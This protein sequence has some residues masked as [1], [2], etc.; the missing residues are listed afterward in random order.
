[1]SS[2]AA[3]EG[4]PAATPLARPTGSRANGWW[5]M[6]LLIATE[7]TLFAVLIASYFY[8]RFKSPVWPPDGINEPTLGRPLLNNGILLA[9]IAPIYFAEYAAVRGRQ[10]LLRLGLLGS[11]LLMLAYF[12][13]QLDSF[14]TSWHAFK[15]SQDTYASLVYAIVGAH[16]LHVGAGILLVAFVFVRALLGHFGAERN[17]PVQ[18]TA[19]YV[20]FVGLLAIP[21]F[22]TS[23]SPAL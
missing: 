9:S 20:H 17:V 14:W 16:W 13:L 5:G 23:V 7:A 15:P 18:V 4:R 21:V 11:L 1:V 6:L 19:L 12:G 2:P 8:I 10:G 22:L 3:V